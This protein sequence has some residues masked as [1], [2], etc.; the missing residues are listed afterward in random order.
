M[1]P[2]CVTLFTTNVKT[3]KRFEVVLAQCDVPVLKKRDGEYYSQYIIEWNGV[4][5]LML[6]CRAV[7]GPT[8]DFGR[9]PAHARWP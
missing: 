3:L 8:S 9:D 4:V 7:V 6:P 1:I 5:P 2:I